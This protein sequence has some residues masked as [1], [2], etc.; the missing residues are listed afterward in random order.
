MQIELLE[1]AA[2]NFARSDMNTGGRRG[3]FT[4]V[5]QNLVPVSRP[6]S[7]YW[8]RYKGWSARSRIP[9]SHLL[10]ATMC[11][12]SLSAVFYEVVQDVKNLNGFAKNRPWQKNVE[13][14]F[15]P[16][17]LAVTRRRFTK[18]SSAERIGEDEG[19]E[20]KPHSFIYHCYAGLVA[21]W[22]QIRQPLAAL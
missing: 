1:Q 14:V 19:N 18:N 5:L 11:S 15:A 9:E 12:P 3:S 6:L 10:P 13:K 2:I 16:G 8:L 21:H 20:L 22:G 17:R 4:Y 7:E